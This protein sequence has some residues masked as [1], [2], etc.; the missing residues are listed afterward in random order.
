MKVEDGRYGMK[1]RCVEGYEPVD[2]KEGEV[3]KIRVVVEK[4]RDWLGEASGFII[5]KPGP[6]RHP[7]SPY[8]WSAHRFEPVE[9][10]G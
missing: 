2:L 4:G 3:L 5:D 1:V 9:E 10:G 7:A 6:E 8:V